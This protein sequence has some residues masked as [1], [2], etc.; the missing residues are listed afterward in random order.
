MPVF[1][2]IKGSGGQAAERG[3]QE[4]YNISDQAAH[5]RNEQRD[6]GVVRRCKLLC[7]IANLSKDAR[8]TANRPG[9]EKENR[10]G[11]LLNVQ[12]QQLPPLPS[13]KLLMFQRSRT[14]ED[15]TEPEKPYYPN[16]ER[17]ISVGKT[18]FLGSIALVSG[19]TLIG[20][21]SDLFR[22]YKKEAQK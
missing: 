9:A 5:Q 7:G 10:E 13:L 19:L 4:Y 8:E 2:G 14:Y 20:I 15:F 12:C 3:H 17:Q 18:V 21:V 22:K 11:R 16:P 6:R 1:Q